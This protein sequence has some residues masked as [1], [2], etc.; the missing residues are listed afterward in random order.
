MEAGAPVGGGDSGTESA[1]PRSL[2]DDAGDLLVD[3]RTWADAEL[4]YQKTR[5][6]FVGNSLKRMVAFGIAGALL[7]LFA[8]GGLTVGLII[9]LTPLVTAWGATAIVVGALLVAALV[10]AKM[11]ARALREMIAAVREVDGEP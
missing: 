3:I 8:L 7:G 5:A 1:T 9:A 4:A 2:L 10:A 6:S 11:A